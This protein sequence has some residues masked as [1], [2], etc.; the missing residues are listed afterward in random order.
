MSDIKTALL[1]LGK[2]YYSGELFEQREKLVKEGRDLPWRILRYQ[3]VIE[4][5]KTFVPLK[6]DCFVLPE[7]F[8]RQLKWLQKHC[9][10]ISLETLLWEIDSAQ[11]IPFNTVAISVD[12]GFVDTLT[13]VLAPCNAQGFPF[14]VFLP[15]AFIQKRDFFWYDKVFFILDSLR[16][17]GYKMRPFPVFDEHI[18]LAIQQLSPEG[19]LSSEVI[20]LFILALQSLDF[21]TRLACLL[22]LGEAGDQVGIRYPKEDVFLRW[23]EIRTMEAVGVSFGSLSH[24]YN[25]FSD[26]NK[27][28][29]LRDLRQAEEILQ[30]ELKQA[31]QLLAF[32]RGLYREETLAAVREFGLKY[33]LG[34]DYVPLLSEAQQFPKV[35]RRV[36]VNEL[37]GAKVEQFF[38]ALWD[39]S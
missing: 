18:K 19:E 2:K 1:N 7:T 27:E 17:E 30:T 37:N 38:S 39:L 20:G 11:P 33:V 23:E 10:V 26:F 13:N 34:A 21:Q 22:T 5:E 12:G 28:Q 15:T 31:S 6:A 8:K 16:R 29:V 35:L 14:S 32:P 4:A 36:S 9:R 3:R 24:S 25:F